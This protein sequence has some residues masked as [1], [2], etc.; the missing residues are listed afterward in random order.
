MTDQLLI[1]FAKNPR[2]GNAKTRL[3]ASLGPQAALMIY[4]QLLD[5]TKQITKD[6]PV[7][8]ALYY[9]ESPLPSELWGDPYIHKKQCGG[10]LGDKMLE[11][12]RW[13]FEQG[14]GR[15]CI[16]GSDC[17]ELTGELVMQAFAS[18][19]EQQV[20]LGPTYDG[21]YYLLG[22]NELHSNL[23]QNKTWGSSRVMQETT[24]DLKRQGLSYK[25][26]SVLNDVDREQDLPHDLKSLLS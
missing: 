17:W 11:A 8:K 13:G 26:L 20:V 2:L 6:L 15:V 14:Y 22:M 3:A 9:S 23:F 25:R 21:G 12:F 5:H 18:L 7:D 16:V 19:N 24:E 10:D 4:Q 1:I